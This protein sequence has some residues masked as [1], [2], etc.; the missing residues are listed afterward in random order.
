[1]S[2]PCPI[3]HLHPARTRLLFGN[4]S[5]LGVAVLTVL[6]MSQTAFAA[7]PTLASTIDEKVT[8]GT[9]RFAYSGSSWTDCGGCN[10][11]AYQSSFKY[12]FI[13]GDKV[14]FTFTGTQA[15]FYGFREQVGGI[16]AVSIDGQ[17]AVDVNYYAATQ[18]P[19]NVF[20]TPVLAQ[21][22]H[23]V[24]FTVTGRRA[25]GESPTINIDKAE[26]YVGGDTPQPP[27][28]IGQIAT[29]DERVLSGANRFSYSGASWTDCGGCNA[30][31][32]QGSFKY[33]YNTGDQAV[34]TFDGT[35]AKFYGFREPVGGIASVSVDGGPAVDVNF[36]AAT[37]SLQNVFNT[38]VLSSGTH[39]VSIA[40][41]GRRSGGSSNT[42]NLDKA[43]VYADGGTPT[44]LWLSGA[45]GDG[46]ANGAF[47]AW[48]GKAVPL[49][50]TWSTLADTDQN[51]RDAM[52]SSWQFDSGAEF[53]Q[54]S[55][56]I[57]WS[58]GAICPGTS[59]DWGP[60]ASGA[61][62]GLWTESLQNVRAKWRNKQ[63]GT[64]Y[65]RFAHEMNGDWYPWSVSPGQIAN[66]KAAWIRFRNIQKQVFPEAKL[67]F[68][69]NGNTVGQA[70]D[71][72]QL[73]PGDAYV[74]VYST[75]WYQGHWELAASRPTDTYGGPVWLELHRQF[76]QAH[77]KPF[78]I[79]EWGGQAD[80]GD[81]PAYIVFMS[82]FANTFGGAGSGNLLYEA[83]FNVGSHDNNNFGI[84]PAT[85]IPNIAAE[86]RNRF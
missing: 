3:Q 77:G 83:Y 39:T 1:M 23:T 9:H 73:W 50:V 82:N 44:R 30:N 67:V 76:A 28:P 70:Y 37:Q 51:C 10:A 6:A 25:G 86:Y 54:W 55:G 5:I 12:A 48:R 17:A 81:K 26:V 56:S 52:R 36:Y 63:R 33:A 66:F 61:Y 19:Q 22:T 69:T 13:T 4:M 62:D 40:V 74:D 27:P 34:F 53:D 8:V 72:R 18:S 31:A 79:P 68:N 57:D 75:D 65:I 21:G 58:M 38:P 16:A 85:K 60:A 29:V 80:H 11:S 2:L 14:T 35:Q 64:F 20:N 41:S 71:W 47:G 15:K 84:Y 42:I 49:A 43:E 46:V 32:Y 59:K 24:V 7:S 45:S 78:A